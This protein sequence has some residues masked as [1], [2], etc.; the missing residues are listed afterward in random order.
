MKR[1]DV[2][3]AVAGITGST[4]IFGG[5]HASAQRRTDDN[6]QQQVE[7]TDQSTVSPETPT[8]TDKPE[9]ET[10]TAETTSSSEFDT[11]VDVVEAG[12]DPNGEESVTALLEEYAA[13]DTLLSFPPGT[14]KIDFF[15]LSGLT[16]FGIVGAGEEPATF[17][18]A[19]GDCRGGHPW[20]ALESI[21]DLLLKNVQFDFRNS[22]S[23]GPVHLLLDGGDS[24]VQDVTYRGSCS[25]QISMFK[26]SVREEGGTALFE[27]VAARND[28]DNQSLTGIY[29]NGGHAGEMTFRDCTAELCSDNGLYASDPGGDSGANGAVHVVDG[30]YRNNNIAGVRLGSTG[31]TARGVTVVVDSET[32]GWGSL[33]AR[34]I[35]L[36]NRAGQRIENCEITFGADAAD[37]FG[38]VVFHPENAGG[39]VIDT[40][41]TI[42]ADGIPATRAFPVETSGG[43]TR[44]ENVSI[45]GAAASGFT[46][47]IEGRD[48]TVFRNCEITQPEGDRAGIRFLDSVDCRVVDSRLEVAE[49]PL[50]VENGSV[51][52]QNTTVVTAD[53]E[54]RID[55]R[56]LENETLTAE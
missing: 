28:E 4:L 48:G 56:V 46:A 32:P 24:T 13:D 36:R 50:V 25:N 21:D 3:T 26:V 51:R 43:A 39:T 42:D 45:A 49:R 7:P 11:V 35:R 23:G 37:S 52:V 1:R 2:L 18:P 15:T 10:S 17:V 20:V 41:I 44:F 27:R 6:T 30:T 19:D 31:S 5:Y 33:N 53:W 9:T 22:E 38:G 8:E 40:D 55:D 34:G 12:A 14:Y 29:V 47:M 54:K 16:T